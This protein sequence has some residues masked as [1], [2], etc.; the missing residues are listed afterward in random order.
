MGRGGLLALAEHVVADAGVSPDQAVL[1]QGAQGL[2]DGF[3]GDSP[4]LGD[5]GDGHGG[6]ALDG[7]PADLAAQVFGDLHV[8]PGVAGDPRRLRH[9]VSRRLAPGR[10][11]LHSGVAVC[12]A[13]GAGGHDGGDHGGDVGGS[14]VVVDLAPI[15]PFHAP[16]VGDEHPAPVG[17]ARVGDDQLSYLAVDAGDGADVESGPGE[18]RRNDSGEGLCELHRRRRGDS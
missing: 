16:V 7:S 8:Q 2:A 11:R 10:G 4:L 1:L 14:G 18:H 3:P 15:A 6:V 9:L 13:G 12:V 5:G 17:L